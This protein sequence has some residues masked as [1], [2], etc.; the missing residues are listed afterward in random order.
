MIAE[1]TEQQVKE[2]MTRVV[3]DFADKVA[4]LPHGNRDETVTPIHD[5]FWKVHDDVQVVEARLL[6]E[7]R[8]EVSRPGARNG[9]DE[10]RHVIARLE[11]TPHDSTLRQI[12]AI[13]AECFR[14]AS[15]QLGI[16][17][18]HPTSPSGKWER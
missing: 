3:R 2:Q 17:P 12:N 11:R 10:L 18:R 4:K 1:F 15:E 8:G 16:S 9:S 14:Q 6:A 5:A 13:A 7:A